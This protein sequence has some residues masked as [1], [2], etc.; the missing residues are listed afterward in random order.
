MPLPFGCLKFHDFLVKKK[1]IYRQAYNQLRLS[2]IYRIYP[3]D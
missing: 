1:N 2:A 3:K